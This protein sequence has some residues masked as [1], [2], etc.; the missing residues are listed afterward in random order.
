MCSI[1]LLIEYNLDYMNRD[2]LATYDYINKRVGSVDI[3]FTLLDAYS[4]RIWRTDVTSFLLRK[5]NIFG[6]MERKLGNMDKILVQLDYDW[7]NSFPSTLGDRRS[8]A[9]S[10]ESLF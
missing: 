6:R 4:A 2:I 8:S 1:Y 5:S 9:K 3:L 10:E 7:V